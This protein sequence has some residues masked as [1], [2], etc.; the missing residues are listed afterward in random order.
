[1]LKA[2][3]LVVDTGLPVAEISVRVGYRSE[4]SFSKMLKKNLGET[5][6]EVRKMEATRH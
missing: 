1:M 5:P 6:G 2:R 3:E 4:F